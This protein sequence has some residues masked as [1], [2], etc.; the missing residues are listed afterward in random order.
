MK[1]AFT[2]AL[3][4]ATAM[5]QY[6]DYDDSDY[7]YNYNETSYANDTMPVEEEF[8][9]EEHFS[10]DDLF[11]LNEDGQWEFSSPVEVPQV[12]IAD[13]DDQEVENWAQ[14]TEQRYI[15][16]DEKWTEAWTEYQSAIATPWND[17]LSQVESLG[18]ERDE[19]DL[20][21]S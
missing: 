20:Q 7:Y 15:E 10:I 8:K 14:E 2:A 19:I 4:V 5:A 16:N 11:V 3:L 21:T 18:A 9:K 17:L 6:D 12:T 1:F 13:V